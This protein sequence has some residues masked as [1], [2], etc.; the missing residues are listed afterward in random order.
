MWFPEEMV[1][2]PLPDEPICV[3]PFEAVKEPPLSATELVATSEPL[4]TVR[5]DWTLTRA[6][7]C[8]VKRPRPPAVL[9]RLRV[10]TLIVA[11]VMEAMPVPA[12]L[13]VPLLPRPSA[14]LVR[15]SVLPPERARE[16]VVPTVVPTNTL[17]M[18]LTL[19]P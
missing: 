13:V 3:R 16:L 4:T 12:P 7:L 18:P 10:V 5:L 14:A 2:K 6:L 1:S 19:P 15:I 17:L 11:P 9:P 8:S